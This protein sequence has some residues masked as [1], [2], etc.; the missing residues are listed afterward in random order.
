MSTWLAFFGTKA[1]E[2]GKKMVIKCLAQ[3]YKLMLIYKAISWK[4]KR[5]ETHSLSQTAARLLMVVA[6]SFLC[7]PPCLILKLIVCFG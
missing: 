3:V 6:H 5:K 2:N 1:E 4:A 7:L